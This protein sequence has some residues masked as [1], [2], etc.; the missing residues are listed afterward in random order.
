MNDGMIHPLGEIRSRSLGRSPASALDFSPPFRAGHSRAATVV[1]GQ[2]SRE[3]EGPSIALRFGDIAG[4]IDEAA[5]AQI[6]HGRL[7]E[8]ER[9]Q[10]DEAAWPF[11]IALEDRRVGSDLRTPARDGDDRRDVTDVARRNRGRRAACGLAAPEENA[12]AAAGIRLSP[13]QRRPRCVCV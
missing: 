7:V 11:A 4:G 3:D 10:H 8:P 12:A 9:R 13:P 2:M 5:E 6:G 1:C